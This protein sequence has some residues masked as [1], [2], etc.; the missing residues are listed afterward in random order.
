MP[1][2]SQLFILIE[3]KNRFDNG[4]YMYFTFLL[5]FEYKDINCITV[6]CQKLWFSLKLQK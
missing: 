6:Y 5:F 3:S 4:F 1:K 2:Q